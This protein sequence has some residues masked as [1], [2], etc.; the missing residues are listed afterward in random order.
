MA[1]A[2]AQN[3][4]ETRSGT[5]SCRGLP[6]VEYIEILIKHK[7]AV[8]WVQNPK[9]GRG[10]D[11]SVQITIQEMGQ[12]Q[13]PSFM[14][15]AL[16]FRAGEIGTGMFQVFSCQSQVNASAP[17]NHATF[18]ITIRSTNDISLGAMELPDI[19]LA[20]LAD[21]FQDRGDYEP[22]KS[23]GSFAPWLVLPWQMLGGKHVDGNIGLVER[24]F[25]TSSVF[26]DI[27]AN[28]KPTYNYVSLF[29]ITTRDMTPLPDNLT[30]SAILT[31]SLSSSLSYLND[32]NTVRQLKFG[33]GLTPPVCGFV[34]DYRSSTIVD[35][36]GSI[37][38]LLAVLQSVHIL[39][40]G[41]PMFWG[42]TGAKLISPFGILGGCHS[43][44]FR[45]RL[46]EQYH[47]QPTSGQALGQAETIRINEF[48]R[49]YVIDF[50]PADIDEEDK[51]AQQSVGGEP[52]L[53][54]NYGEPRRGEEHGVT[55]SL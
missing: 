42:L 3:Q 17:F 41:R 20:N 13:C 33:H 36:I 34:E 32:V 52:H 38:G 55:D 16:S 53:D 4:I 11:T 46:R 5:E 26:R 2:Q 51:D 18:N 8:D 29:T 1:L 47:H 25:T 45:R 27:V 21:T 30:A 7:G 23:L 6:L 19:W 28:L 44:G 48:L 9:T 24:R 35:V 12:Y 15:R 14:Q 22:E 10:Y 43:R 49:D 37:G 50:G 54:T 39:L 31:P 40:F